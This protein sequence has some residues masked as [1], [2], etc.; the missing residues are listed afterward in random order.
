M[1]QP[2]PT[3]QAVALKKQIKYAYLQTYQFELALKCMIQ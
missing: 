3:K 2:P 1:L